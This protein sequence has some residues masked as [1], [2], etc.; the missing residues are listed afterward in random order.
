MAGEGRMRGASDEAFLGDI[1]NK[2]E[3]EVN[4]DFG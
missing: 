2:A 4:K 1:S 3:T